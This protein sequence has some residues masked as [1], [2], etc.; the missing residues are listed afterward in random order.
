V[1]PDPEKKRYYKISWVEELARSSLSK[2]GGL[3]WSL[4]RYIPEPEIAWICIQI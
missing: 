2:V 4:R 3:S 1:D